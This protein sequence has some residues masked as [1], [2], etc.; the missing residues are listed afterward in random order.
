MERYFIIP[1]I[2]IWL[3]GFLFNFVLEISHMPYYQGYFNVYNRDRNVEKKYWFGENTFQMR[4]SFAGVFWFAS[5]SDA[6]L[7]L[8][9]YWVVSLIFMDRFWFVDGG[10]LFG[11][12]ETALPV[13]AGY[14]VALLLGIFWQVVIELI[15]RAKNWWGYSPEMP[16]LGKK[17]ALLPNIQMIIPIILSLLLT[18]YVILG[19]RAASQI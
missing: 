15:G 13:Q 11:L 9:H 1:E 5:A 17:F 18:R 3:F 12:G 6:F 4:K 16:M 10:T 8:G 7:V 19:L 14:L 2:Y